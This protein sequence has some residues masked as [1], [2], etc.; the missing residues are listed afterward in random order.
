MNKKVIGII[1]AVVVVLLVIVGVVMTTRKSSAP[2][3]VETS[4]QSQQAGSPQ[5][6][7]SPASSVVSSIKDAMGLGKQMK[8]TYMANKTNTTFSATVYVEGNKYKSFVTVGGK[9]MNALFDGTAL[10][11]WEDGNTTGSEMTADCLVKLKA[12]APQNPSGPA[13]A[14]PPVQDPADS[15]NSATNVQCAPATDGDLTVP[16]G[17]TFSDQCA[18]MTKA[19]EYM[20]KTKS[21][22]G[23]NVPNIPANIPGM[24]SGTQQ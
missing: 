12:A 15:F 22:A 7:T 11:T 13:P 5:Q 17:V 1:V 6:P 24:P 4:V 18:M 16:A 2:Q 21:S 14:Q 9:N 3:N 19:L 23:A 8:C 10:Y 20:N